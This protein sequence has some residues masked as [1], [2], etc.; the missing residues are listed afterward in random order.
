MW[1]IFQMLLFFAKFPE[2]SNISI[3]NPIEIFHNF[4]NFEKIGK[5]S[6]FSENISHFFIF[7]DDFFMDFQIFWCS[8][9]R[10]CPLLIRI[11]YLFTKY[12]AKC[13]FSAVQFFFTSCVRKRARNQEYIFIKKTCSY[14]LWWI[15]RPECP[16][17][18]S[19]PWF[20]CHH[21]GNSR[22]DSQCGSSISLTFLFIA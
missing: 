16:E 14:I 10:R 6:L 22:C 12:S 18:F 2:I 9:K 11:L 15:T 1:N 21:S 3:E 13:E 8:V 19:V 4:G 17:H 20:F 7:W 5:S